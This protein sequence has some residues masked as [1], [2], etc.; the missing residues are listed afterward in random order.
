MSHAN[1]LVAVEGPSSDIQS[2]VTHQMEPFDE[3]GM[4][5][6]KGS[7]WDWWRIG[8]RW[9]GYLGGVNAIRRNSLDLDALRSHREV[10]LREHH[11]EAV[12]YA[13]KNIEFLYNVKPDETIDAYLAR[14]MN[15]SCFPCF[16]A[17]L[18]NRRWNE[19]NRLG[20]F[21]LPAKTECE[22]AGKDLRRCLVRDRKTGAAI[23]SWGDDPRWDEEFF[24]RF[25]GG[26]EPE[27][28]LVVV[29]YHV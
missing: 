1:L 15:G 16:Y 4:C 21:G 18:H 22:V 6:R 3:N 19:C 13:G 24:D 2:L 10:Q 8:G 9:D 20:F 14:R 5:F 25:V 23:V 27:I 28:M 29:D 26:L 17:F 7:R 12:A 11:A